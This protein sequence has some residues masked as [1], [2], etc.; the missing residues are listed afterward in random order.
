[1]FCNHILDHMVPSIFGLLRNFHIGFQ[2]GF[3]PFPSPSLV[4]KLPL[5]CRVWEAGESR[6]AVLWDLCSGS[7]LVILGEPSVVLEGQ[8]LSPC[9][10]PVQ[11]P[12][13]PRLCCHHLIPIVQVLGGNLRQFC[14]VELLVVCL[15]ATSMPSLEDPLPL[16]RFDHLTFALFCVCFV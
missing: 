12:L 14:D 1:M 2:N 16:S 13:F 10:P 11:A 3:Y 7:L 6:L 4:H 8:C 9:T 5:Y 15:W